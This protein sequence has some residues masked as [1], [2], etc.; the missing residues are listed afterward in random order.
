[1]GMFDFNDSI[2]QPRVASITTNGMGAGYGQMG[3]TSFGGQGVMPGLPG[4]NGIIS[5]VQDQW[6]QAQAANAARFKRIMMLAKQF[7]ATALSD[8]AVNTKN[9]QAQAGQ[10]LIGRGLGNSSVVSTVKSGI[11]QRG[12]RN[13]GSIKEGT[14]GLKMNA[15]QQQQDQYPNLSA[16]A[17]LM[18]QPR[19]AA[20][21]SVGG[22]NLPFG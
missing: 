19:A 13:A 5:G 3:Q 21:P 14:A 20:A 18:Q 8:N 17:Q 4:D 16:Y 1:M 12:Q 7:G 9:L 2:L 22:S 6:N 15:L 10:D 11:A